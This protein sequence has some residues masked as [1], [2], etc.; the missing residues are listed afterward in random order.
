M[1]TNN[2]S[3]KRFSLLLALALML[4]AVGAGVGLHYGTQAIAEGEAETAE[5]AQETATYDIIYSSGNPVP[6]IAANVRPSIVQVIDSSAAW[7]PSTRQVTTQE[8][9]YGSGTYI[10]ALDGEDGGYILTNNHVIEDAE[11][12]EILWLDGTRMD[13]EIVGAD[14][15]TDVAVLKFSEPAPADATPVPLGDSDALQVGEL[16]IVIGNPGAGDS[17]LFGTVTAGIVS[18]LGRDS[19]NA[20]NFSR[21]VSV[22]QV[23]AAINSGNSG[24]ALLNAKGE[25]VGIPTLKMMYSYSSIYEGLGFCI[26]INTAKEIANQ[27]ITNGKVVRP[28]IGVA[29]QDFDGPDEAISSWPPAGIQITRVE[30]NSPAEEAGLQAGDVIAEID[31]VRVKTYTELTTEIDK[32][33]AG[34]TVKLKVYRYYDE[35]GHVLRQYQV[36]DVDVELEILD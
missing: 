13:C 32:H 2:R 31:G 1:K 5:P 7:D 27:L 11:K 21:S 26:P 20:R 9:G 22:I 16:A 15:G 24:G 30:E 28:R 14:D 3:I 34:D 29:V 10:Q 23:D 6:E 18:G 25:L 36:L 17:V 8:I 19:I 4:A 12:V 35:N 33:Q